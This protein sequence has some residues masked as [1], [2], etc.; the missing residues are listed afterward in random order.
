MRKELFIDGA[1]VASH[2]DAVIDVIN[3]AT[4]EVVGQ[5]AAGNSDDIDDAVAAARNAFD[6]GPW[7]RMSG[8]GRAV[9]LRTIAKLLSARLPEF[10]KYESLDVGKPIAEAELDIGDTISCFEYYAD[11]AEAFDAGNDQNLELPDDA[12]SGYLTREP[13]GV[14]GAIVPWNFPLA[15]SSWKIAPALAAGCTMVLKPSEFTPVSAL[16]LADVCIEAGLPAGVLNIVTG[17]G[18]DVGQ[19]LSEHPE[20]DKLTFTG[21]S[22]TGTR[23]MTAA[24]QGT[25]SV[26]LELGGKS[27]A[28]IF[29][30]CDLEKAVEWAMFGIFY[31]QG[32][33]CSA[34][35]RLIIEESIYTRFLERMVERTKEIVIG[36][37]A[38]DGIKLGPLVSQPQYEKVLAAISRGLDDGA[39]LLCGG[40]RPEGMNRG[41]FVEPTIF[42]DV[43]EGHWIWQEE[44]FGPVLCAKSFRTEEEAVR[45]A[46]NSDF[47]LAAAVM[48]SDLN[49]CNRVARAFQAGTVWINCSQ[50][51]F[52]Q[53]SWG[54]YKKSGIGRELGVQGFNNYLEV[55]QVITNVNNDAVAWY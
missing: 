48:S 14:I 11:L 52:V 34:T 16:A 1:W 4:E 3:P 38:G 40:A 47:G 12:F 2:S 6:N 36:D 28:V 39:T 24:A 41:Y 54:G 53:G 25:R 49:V 29:A 17:Y 51:L 9:Y 35:S 30:D 15:M 43:D 21:S 20:V 18:L 13:V 10:A 7:P 55:K 8:S 22:L 44:I 37:G 32:E 31:N 27:A 23:V 33:V 26:G 19:P 5:V 42:T 46:N 50:P 45:M